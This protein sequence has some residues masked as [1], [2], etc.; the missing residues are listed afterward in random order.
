M[1]TLIESCKLNGVDPQ[2][3]LTDILAR[4]ADHPIKQIDDLI[5]WRWPK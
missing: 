4:I 3:Y 1:Y 5:P 2:A